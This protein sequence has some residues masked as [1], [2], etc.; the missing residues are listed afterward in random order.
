M[1]PPETGH[2][3]QP[4]RRLALRRRRLWSWR[5]GTA[6]IPPPAAEELA[7][8]PVKDR[9]DLLNQQRQARHLTFNTIGI[10]FGVVFTAASLIATALTL[11]AT[12][13]AQI[14]DRYTKAVE[15]LGSNKRDVRLGAIYALERIASDSERDRPTIIAVLAAFVREHDPAPTAKLPD[16]PHTDVHAAL[17]VLGHQP[18][19]LSGG[20][21]LDLHGIRIRGGQFDEASLNPVLNLRQADLDGADLSLTDFSG[22][23]LR[24]ARLVRAELAGAR[25]S[26]TDLRGAGLSGTDLRRSDLNHAELGGADL[27]DAVLRGAQMT[28]ADLRGAI[29]D[30][31]DLR[32]A[33]LVRADLR[34]ASLLDADL[35]GITGITPAAVRRLAITNQ[36]TRLF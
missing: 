21:R 16:E 19:D 17:T 31:A 35:R 14:T 9:V 20:R 6:P 7:G 11:R 23:N 27:G 33:I 29:L 1:T 34:G 36:N 28:G 2:D 13:E 30:N 15:Q 5:Q 8:L 22:A 3:R 25:M 24:D 10:L 18:R 26:G 12:Q 4:A 32:G